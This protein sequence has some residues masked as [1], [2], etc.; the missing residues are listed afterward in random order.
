MFHFGFSYVGLIYLVMLFLPNILWTKNQPAG[1][2]NYVK[3][4][5]KALQILERIGEVTVCCGMLIFTDFN[6]RTDSAWC[7]W[8][9]ISFLLML[10]YEAYW[11]RYFKSKKRMADFYRGICGIPLAGATLPVM[12]FFLL[13]IYGRNSI[14]LIATVILGIGHIGIHAG[15]RKEI[16]TF[17]FEVPGIDR[18][19]EALAYIREFYEYG[20]DING[21]GG[22]HRFLDDY[23]GWLEKLKADENRAA[24]EEKV[25]SRTFFLVRRGDRKIVGMINI[26]LALN[27]RLKK[28][29]GHI[30]YSIRPVERGKGYNKVNLYLGLKVC[31][32]Y[33]IPKVLLD[34]DSNNPASWRTMEALGGVKI[35][36]YFDD[37]NA[38]CMVRD[39]E[40]DVSKSIADYS[41][42]YEPMTV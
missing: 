40:I 32:K 23:E 9:L 27:E 5:S 13:G 19:D 31:Q 42:V 30:G 26:R 20:S 38:H 25:P 24:D 1:Y 7:I 16:E 21:A 10:L 14:L 8:L 29:G 36:E 34:A 11:V 12:A 2:E 4:E 37:E 41:A 17:Y 15:H 3:N 35:R 22:L 6:V 18:K 28:S 39:Y 33:G